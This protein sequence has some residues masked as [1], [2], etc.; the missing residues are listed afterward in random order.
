MVMLKILPPGAFDAFA[1]N[2][3]LKKNAPGWS[4]TSTS[5]MDVIDWDETANTVHLGLQKLVTVGSKITG[6][7]KTAL[8]PG[9]I[10]GKGMDDNI[11]HAI[12]TMGNIWDNFNGKI[13]NMV[14][15]SRG[16][17]T[18]IRMANWLEE[19]YGTNMEVNIFAIDPVAGGDLGTK[20]GDTYTLPSIVKNY[21]SL[22]ALDDKRGGFRP[23]D[24]KRIKVKDPHIT[25]VAHLPLPGSHDTALK[26]GKNAELHEVSEVARHLSYQFLKLMG[27]RF[28]SQP[29]L[30]TAAQLCDK[31]AR[32]KLKIGR[33]DKLGKKGFS[34]RVQGGI[35]Q[36]EIKEKH[37]D[38]V[39]NSSVFFMNEHHVQ[40][41]LK[42]FPDIF[43]YFFSAERVE[44]Q[45]GQPVSYPHHS[46]WARKFY[47]LL[48]QSPASYQLLNM[49]DVLMSDNSS[50]YND[51]WIAI[52]NSLYVGDTSTMNSGRALLSIEFA[53][54]ISQFFG[55]FQAI[56]I[57]AH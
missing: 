25:K 36:R 24:A 23:Q 13:I 50:G 4:Q 40:L 21:I 17:V 22:L 10:L 48:D 12:A 55:N 28:R 2:K 6:K 57:K 3:C 49:L 46:N 52:P 15:W 14:G 9:L 35:I 11:R 45:L 18:C 31:Y 56:S 51:I 33:Y 27:T 44:T 41:F 29:A 32:M 20:S 30:Y 16:A 1:Q 42:T 26:Y 53:Q 5:I 7:K 38:Y 47:Q 34:K 39:S 37:Y 19:F 43:R 54:L 8:L